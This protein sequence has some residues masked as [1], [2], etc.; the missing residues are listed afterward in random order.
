MAN[1]TLH[2]TMWNWN[3]SPRTNA[4]YFEDTFKNTNIAMY[5]ETHQCVTIKLIVKDYNS[6]VPTRT[7][8]EVTIDSA[9]ALGHAHRTRPH[10][11]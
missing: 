7:C 1:E 3:S 11:P 4:E 10:G 9:I 8:Q 6:G 5:K 2:M